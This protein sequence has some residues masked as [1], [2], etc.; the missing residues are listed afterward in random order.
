MPSLAWDDVICAKN[1]TGA[2]PVARKLWLISGRELHSLGA[3]GGRQW[4][5]SRNSVRVTHPLSSVSVS[6]D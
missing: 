3:K 5:R 4:G 6:R 2:M 1:A